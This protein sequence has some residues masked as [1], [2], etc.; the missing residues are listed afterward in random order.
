[1]NNAFD[2][3]EIGQEKL[4]AASHNKDKSVRAQ[5]LFKEDNPG[6]HNLIEKFYDFTGVPAL[7]NTSLN[8]HGY[9]L[10]SNPDQLLFTFE[11]SELIYCFINDEVLIK[12]NDK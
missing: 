5:I 7:L 1:M 9:P 10:V 8:V 11:N 12:K 4:I 6:Y 3:T 2:S